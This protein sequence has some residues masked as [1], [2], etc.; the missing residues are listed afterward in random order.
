MMNERRQ[1]SSRKGMEVRNQQ[2]AR[3]ALRRR[4]KAK[5]ARTV[6]RH[7]RYKEKQRLLREMEE[8]QPA[9]PIIAK[10]LG[11]PGDED[12][13]DDIAVS[14]TTGTNTNSNLDSSSEVDEPDE[15][16][17]DTSTTAKEEKIDNVE[18]VLDEKNRSVEEGGNESGGEDLEKKKHHPFM[19]QMKIAEEARKE[20]EKREKERKQRIK[21]RER[22]LKKSKKERKTKV[23][24]LCILAHPHIHRIPIELN[25][26]SLFR[27]GISLL[28]IH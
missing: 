18:K 26:C 21:V 12:E 20:R 3:D 2:A 4:Q 23:C 5:K 16:N 22:M 11:I 24:L 28:C 8:Q 10:E 19:K 7:V 14:K 6:K 15:A 13:V 1:M 9:A 27:V 17:L 25:F